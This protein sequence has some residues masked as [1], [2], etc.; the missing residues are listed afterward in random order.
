MNNGAGARASAADVVLADDRA[1]GT[2]T[3]SHPVL[4]I[5]PVDTQMLARDMFDRR[6]IEQVQVV[7]WHGRCRLTTIVKTQQGFDE[8]RRGARLPT[9][10][11]R[12]LGEGN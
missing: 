11:D 2:A 4:A 7:V 9:Y 5:A 1:A 12:K 6:I 8:P 3:V 10:A